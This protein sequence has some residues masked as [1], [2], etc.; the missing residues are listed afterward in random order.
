MSEWITPALAWGNME[1]CEVA[2]SKAQARRRVVE[3]SR[4]QQD[5]R[6]GTTSSGSMKVGKSTHSVDSSHKREHIK[7]SCI[8]ARHHH[9]ICMVQVGRWLGCI[10]PVPSKTEILFC[11]QYPRASQKLSMTW[12]VHRRLAVDQAA[13]Q[14]VAR[15]DGIKAYGWVQK[16]VWLVFCTEGLLHCCGQSIHTSTRP[17]CIWRTR[18]GR[19]PR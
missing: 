8:N 13:G 18:K 15:G 16:Q 12:M 19:A 5:Q 2:Y 9:W 1:T 3:V 6:L 10:D 11:H 4:A 14:A 17:S 7:S